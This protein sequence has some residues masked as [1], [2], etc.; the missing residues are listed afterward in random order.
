MIFYVVFPDYN[1]I[2]IRSSKWTIK[3]DGEVDVYN[4]NLSIKEANK[5]INIVKQN[6]KN[7][8][9]TT[10]IYNLSMYREIFVE[11]ELVGLSYEEAEVKSQK[12]KRKN[13]VKDIIE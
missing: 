6:Y 7:E 8:Y 12:L 3:K 5:L 13:T 2:P 1:I 4:I 9:R 10:E 11:K